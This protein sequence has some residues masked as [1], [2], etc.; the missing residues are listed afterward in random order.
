MA[1]AA[2]AAWA[3]S[4]NDYV[5]AEVGAKLAVAGSVL[6][7]PLVLYIDFLVDLG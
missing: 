7:A 2:S 3:P 6:L 1:S 4:L 5:W